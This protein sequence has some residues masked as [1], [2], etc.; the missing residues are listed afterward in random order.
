MTPAPLAYLSIQHVTRS[1]PR[2]LSNAER[3]HAYR[4]HVTPDF[5]NTTFSF[6]PG[7]ASATPI[8]SGAGS[9]RT[10][11]QSENHQ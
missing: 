10:Y 7:P 9:R 1:E 11:S 6:A 5:A 2:V 3:M 4:Q 8:P